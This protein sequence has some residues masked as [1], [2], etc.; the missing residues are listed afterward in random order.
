MTITLDNVFYMINFNSYSTAHQALLESAITTLY[1]GSATAKTMLES[2]VTENRN[3]S[4]DYIMGNI[5]QT[6]YNDG[7]DPTIRIDPDWYEAPDV[8]YIDDKGEVTGISLTRSIAHELTHAISGLKDPI[9]ADFLSGGYSTP[10]QLRGDT[11]DKENTIML[12]LGD[13]N[14]RASYYSARLFHKP[15]TVPTFQYSNG[16]AIDTAVYTRTNL[17][18]SNFGLA[19]IVLVGDDNSE[20]LIT[21]NGNDYLWGWDGNDILNGGGGNDKLHGGDQADTYVFSGNYGKDIVTDSG[22]GDKI[23]INGVVIQGDAIEGGNESNPNPGI[24]ELKG[25]SFE[26][27]GAS[28]FIDKDES[29]EIELQNWQDGDYG[30]KLVPYENEAGVAVLFTP[31]GAHYFPG[32]RLDLTS[33]HLAYSI[34]GLLETPLAI[35]MDGD[36]IE[37]VSIYSR[38]FRFDMN[39]DGFAEYTGWLD[40]DDGFLVVD[41]NNNGVIDNQTEMFGASD[42]GVSAWDKLAAYDSNSD[43]KVDSSDANWSELLIWKDENQNG[44]SEAFELLSPIAAGIYGFSLVQDTYLDESAANIVD[45]RANWL[46]SNGNA[47]GYYYDVFFR[48]NQIDTEYV[49]NDLTNSPQIDESA[50]KY[51]EMRG[52]GT[53][54]SLTYAASNNPDLSALLDVLVAYDYT[55]P[56]WV[57]DELIYNI[58]YEWSD[59]AN[60]ENVTLSTSDE[61]YERGIILKAFYGGFAS[62]SDGA[63]NVSYWEDFTSVAQRAIFS[64][65]WDKFYDGVKAG[66]LV[67]TAYAEIFPNSYYSPLED[68]VFAEERII[69]NDSLENILANASALAPTDADEANVFWANL[70]KILSI[71]DPT[72]S[73]TYG[74]QIVGQETASVVEIIENY[75]N[76]D[77]FLSADSLYVADGEIGKITSHY[78]GYQ[79]GLDP[80]WLEAPQYLYGSDG[81]NTLI[82]GEGNDYI[83]GNDGNDLIITTSGSD[84]LIGGDGADIFRVDPVS[85]DLGSIS[86]IP[87][88]YGNIKDYV[89]GLDKIDI[90][91]FSYHYGWNTIVYNQQPQSNELNI[92]YNSQTDQT[93]IGSYQ[94]VYFTLDGDFTNLLDSNDFIFPTYGTNNS[95]ILNAT[96]S[97][98]LING[99]DG[100]DILSGSTG[101]D[102]LIGNSGNDTIYSSESDDFLIGGAG[103]DVYFYERGFGNDVV[104]DGVGNNIVYFGFGTSSD[105]FNI[106][107]YSDS[108]T[109]PKIS[110]EFDDG[111]T[112]ILSEWLTNVSDSL[113]VLDDKTF[114]Q[115][116][117]LREYYTQQA[118]EGN[119]YIISLFSESVD[120]VIYAKAGNDTI[121]GF[122]GN[123]ILYGEDGNDDLW[124]QRGDDI[125]YGG[126]GSDTLSGGYGLGSTYD[127]FGMDTFVFH[128]ESLSEDV[129]TDFDLVGDIIDLSHSSLSQLNDYTDLNAT[130]DGDDVLLTL[131]NN[132]LI[133]ILNVLINEL[134]NSSFAFYTLPSAT[135]GDDTLY[136]SYDSEEIYGLG[137]NDSIYG[138]TGNDTLDG[139]DGDDTIYG[140]DGD[141][142]IYGSDGYD[143]IYGG[144]GND[145]LNGGAGQDTQ[146][147]GAGADDIYGSTASYAS[148]TSGVQASLL[149]T[150]QHGGDA[151]GDRLYNVAHL[152][153][154]YGDDELTGNSSGNTLIGGT[155]DDTIIGGGAA[156]LLTGGAGADVFRYTSASHSV[157][158]SNSDR[159]VDFEVGVDTI[160]LTGLGFYGLTSNATTQTGELR[161]EYLSGRTYIRSDQSD[162]GIRLEGN[163]TGTLS[164]A[165]FM[166][167][168]APSQ[169]IDF[170]GEQ[171]WSYAGSQ[172]AAGSASIVDDGNGI[173]I[174]GNAWKKVNYTYE[175]TANTVLTFEYLSSQQGELQAIGL[176]TDNDFS[177]SPIYQLYGTESLP[178]FHYD[179]DYTGAGEWQSFSIAVG[180][181]FTGAITYLAFIND[182]DNGYR[183]GHS[184]Y[185]NISLHESGNAPVNTA[186]ES[187]ADSYTL[188][189]GESFTADAATG[190]LSND[191]DADSDVLTAV[192]VG[193]VSHGTLALNADGSF[194]Y[195]HDGSANYEDSF[196]YVAYD[197]TENSNIVTVALSVTP[198]TQGQTITGDSSG[199]TLIGGVGDD[200][201]DGARGADSIFGGAGDD[202]II[203]GYDFDTLDGGDG[204]DTAS[205]THTTSN[206]QVD[207]SANT[208]FNGAEYIYNFE[209]IITGTGSDN[210]TGDAQNNIIHSGSNNDY[211]VGGAG[212]DTI[213]GE[214]GN[215]N[216]YGQNGNDTLISGTGDDYL[217][218]GD[219]ADIFLYA[220]VSDSS[221]N[222]G[223]DYIGDFV[224]GADKIDVSAL[225]YTDVSNFSR[226][227]D[228]SYT[229]Y[230]DSATGFAL[231]LNGDYTLTNADFVLA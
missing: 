7:G 59:V 34:L 103:D 83:N 45:G 176:E 58:L 89:D 6:A 193:D 147:G 61:F 187:V 167:D 164:N 96:T 68:K 17:D 160:D 174:T 40:A 194:N 84:I 214:A 205:F 231:G 115:S 75:L 209:N 86:I 29:N 8:M 50:L 10:A 18:M 222:D 88:I 124:G 144:A 198:A 21:A 219:G 202:F 171:I 131:G 153:G 113:V 139:G 76:N 49:G 82:G 182:H 183:N 225:G 210:I 4:F 79:T 23:I 211:V 35:D 155:G 71:S 80:A 47:G 199:N 22:F 38:N 136:G 169:V 197:G 127:S 162:F 179:Y 137:G 141:D 99:L 62:F 78:T 81:D 14:N 24:Y 106:S 55:T 215:D 85:W 93:K 54:P 20:N 73:L 166:F 117:W 129:I 170:T 188:D 154:G 146:E 9:V 157:L 140:G 195:T 161:L 114:T 220:A 52:Q 181:D 120:E 102:Y 91:K 121:E 53:V 221:S 213:Y 196:S 87:G 95:N 66:L 107:F 90:S 19:R 30:I 128:L 168:E 5:G 180:E 177:N 74:N 43:S 92:T 192:L 105:D 3:L 46:D 98:W 134:D 67:Q 218:G 42:N 94:G 229:E 216:L 207:L 101:M 173:E 201:I 133:R 185:R 37:L 28:L 178:Y 149:V 186:P 132:H 172:D 97:N 150:T 159:I 227:A 16:E 151:E 123:D 212:D 110:L 65:E 56:S 57:L 126:D 217:E 119:D 203:G 208:S 51:P 226:Y 145:T 148:D 143:V 204:N 32:D 138:E 109:G 230:Y 64:M 12:E 39:G 77:I 112:L 15:D 142:V 135:E 122:R 48:V 158:P 2:L 116:D 163:Y 44:Y 70:I 156:D 184:H 63:E 11:V 191:L 190:V 224:Q 228:G 152:I 200:T 206:V 223:V 108:V 165:D 118:T 111:E 36:G 13:T 60:I 104:R 72:G 41:N 189:A 130:Q 33:T 100:N 125:L 1:N 69:F 25:H 175:V 31:S 26:M 27:S